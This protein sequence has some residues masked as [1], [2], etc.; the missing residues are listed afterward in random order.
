DA[1]STLRTVLDESDEEA[2]VAYP[3]ELLDVAMTRLIMN[4]ADQLPVVNRGDGATVI[5][6]IDADAIAMAW[7]DRQAKESIREK[8]GVE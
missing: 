2:A 3:D 6:V 1:R 7:H 4:G 8:G 5:G